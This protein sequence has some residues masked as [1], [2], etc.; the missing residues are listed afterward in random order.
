MLAGRVFYQLYQLA[1]KNGF[2]VFLELF[3]MK[4]LAV[5]SQGNA[6]GCYYGAY[7]AMPTTVFY[8]DEC[9]LPLQLLFGA[10]GD[11]AVIS[12]RLFIDEGIL[13]SEGGADCVADDEGAW[14][15]IEELILARVGG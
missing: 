9:A 8:W 13:G 1:A 11:F 7:A 14:K 12:A 10:K 3:D 2:E 15:G 5:I 4:G 6:G